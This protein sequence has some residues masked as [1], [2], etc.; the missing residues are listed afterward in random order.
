MRI[1]SGALATE[2]NSFSPVPTSIR[3]F[4]EGLYFKGLGEEALLD[5]PGAEALKT[6]RDRASAMGADFVLGPVA[7]AEPSG[8]TTATAYASLKDD[9]L[10]ALAEAGD[11]EMVLLALH[12]AMMADGCDDVEGDLLT[13]VRKQVGP[14]TVIGALIDPHAHLTEAMVSASTLLAAYHKWPHTDVAV[15]ADHLFD[16]LQAAAVG[17][18]RPI[19]SVVDCRMVASYPTTQQPMRK[20][21]DDMA[22]AELR[23][24]LLSVNLIH[25]FPWGDTADTGTKMLVW[26]D[27]APAAAAAAATHFSESLFDIREA[28]RLKLDLSMAEA[29]DLIEQQ[30]DGV[31]VLCDV[32][33]VVPA[34]APGDSTYML[35]EA[36]ERGVGEICFGPLWDPLATAVCMDVG[37]G[38]RVQL[39]IGGK[40]GAT[41][42]QPIDALVTVRAVVLDGKGVAKRRF[43]DRA[44]VTLDG[45]IELVLHSIRASTEEISAVTDLGIDLRKSHTFVGKMLM[46]GGAAFAPLSHRIYSVETPGTLAFPEACIPLKKVQSAWWPKENR[47]SFSE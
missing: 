14:E 29:Y 44:W 39:R 22:E 37:P 18:I 31:L 11:V 23:A 43:G 13:S 41:S 40:A 34:G 32:G 20:F 24:P 45:G 21:V 1:F 8:L 15:R 30:H 27:A 36:I 26:S 33:D 4:H 7:F 10:N 12:G 19:P 35:R 5:R 38:S 9:L 46:H 17:R 16:L 6:W 2:T 47:Q 25:G 3:S 28:A 42:G